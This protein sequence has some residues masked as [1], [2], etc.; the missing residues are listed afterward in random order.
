M[1]INIYYFLSCAVA[2]KGRSSR[3]IKL[4]VQVKFTGLLNNC[5]SS[6]GSRVQS[7]GRIYSFDLQNV[8]YNSKSRRTVAGQPSRRVFA[9]DGL[10][11]IS[12]TRICCR[13]ELSRRMHASPFAVFDLL[14][15]YVINCGP[16]FQIFYSYYFY[17]VRFFSLNLC[18][19][20]PCVLVPRLLL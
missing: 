14:I 13:E 17:L 2:I 1:L 19:V 16:A 10:L 18:R 12:L 4:P 9:S 6:R 3:V 15:C 11:F 8:A 5:V 20:P 7:I